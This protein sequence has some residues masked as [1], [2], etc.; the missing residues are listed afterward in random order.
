MSIRTII[1][2][3]NPREIEN[4]CNKINDKDIHILNKSI[5]LS[6][7]SDEVSKLRPNLVLITCSD[8]NWAFR[9]CQQI[10]LLQ[11]NIATILI[12]TSSDYENVKKAID[13]GATGFV[14][15]DEQVNEEIKKI[16]FN[17]QS[18]L[19]MLLENSG[20]QRKAQVISVFGTKGGIGKTTLAV[21]LA[22]ALSRKKAKV[23]I[24]DLDLHFGDAH[25]FLGLDVKETIT[26]LLQEQKVPTIDSIRN[27]FVHHSS[28]VQVLCSPISPEYADGI[29]ASQVEPIINILRTY[30]DYI[31]ID[32]SADF[33]ELNLLM[34]EESSTIL[35][36]TG[37]D[38]SLLNNSK[39]GL[40]LLDS[41]NQKGKVKVVLSRDFK[42]DISV[43][44][45]EKIMDLKVVSRI[46]NDYS[47]AV[48][49]LN[50]GVPIVSSS[51]KSMI[52][53]EINKLANSFIPNAVEEGSKAVKSKFKL[54]FIKGV[55]K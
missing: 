26:E 22:V 53:K 15:L 35:Y 17:H 5:N 21:N 14:T 37:L 48:R 9:A 33:S 4:I 11:P 41:L 28:G 40:L 34:L 32:T 43:Y 30:Y 27:Y 1:F 24:L 10:T 31:I 51:G 44:D 46:P 2:G 19:S 55:V 45:V 23:A 12:S 7:A 47:E 16:Y 20:I 36:V 3:E 25:M 39:K 42:T 38:I 50:Q 8:S 29:T 52:A 49:A 54:P 6:N 18:K 13:S